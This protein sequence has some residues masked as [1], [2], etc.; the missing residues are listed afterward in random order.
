MARFTVNSQRFDPYKKFKFRVRIDGK[1]AGAVAKISSLTKSVNTKSKIKVPGRQK[2]P[3]LT[4]KRGT[5][6]Q[7]KFY[8]WMAAIPGSKNFPMEIVIEQLDVKGKLVAAYHLN[9]AFPSKVEG[10]ALNADGNE[11]LI[12]SIGL[13][14]EGLEIR[15][16]EP[17]TRKKSKNK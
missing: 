6:K 13:S 2:F 7:T 4:L 15:K 11:V 5:F 10:P 9:N 12:E 8:K 1:P 14:H 3:N 17:G 16:A